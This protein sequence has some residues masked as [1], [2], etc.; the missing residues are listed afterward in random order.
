MVST[1]PHG[2]AC[3][4]INARSRLAAGFLLGIAAFAP[5]VIF[6]PWQVAV[7]VGWDTMAATFVGSVFL[8]TRGKDCAATKQMA[9]AEDNS[10]VAA[11]TVLV[12]A[13]VASLVA[14]SSRFSRPAA[15]PVRLIF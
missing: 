6:T 9:T 3:D 12:G 14:W 5:A 7:L 15:K 1:A 13:S 10:R 4:G 2:S 8:A 11:D